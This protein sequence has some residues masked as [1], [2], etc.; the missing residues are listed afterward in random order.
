V[1]VTQLPV[2]AAP[3]VDKA[4]L[5]TAQGTSWADGVIDG[6]IV[7]VWGVSDLSGQQ[8]TALLA[9]LTAGTAG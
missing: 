5:G 7:T 9:A 3:G 4:R 6:A 1:T 8:A 2:A